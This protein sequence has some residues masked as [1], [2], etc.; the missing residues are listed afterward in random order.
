[1]KQ[2][3]LWLRI[4][5]AIRENAAAYLIRLLAIAAYIAGSI[6][7]SRH[8]GDIARAAENPLTSP[9]LAW[10]MTHIRTVFQA[11]GGAAVVFLLF[12]PFDR[13]W[14]ENPT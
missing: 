3:K 9:N 5:Y 10:A 8:S 1:M 2:N 6:Y 11:A 12:Y 4:R 7:V 13:R 14:T